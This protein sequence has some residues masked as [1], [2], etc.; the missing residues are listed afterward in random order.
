[1]PRQDDLNAIVVNDLTDIKGRIQ[2]L[3]DVLNV[4]DWAI[5]SAFEQ[6]EE[7]GHLPPEEGLLQEYRRAI[8]ILR[9]RGFTFPKSSGK[10]VACPGCKALL[11]D[12]EGKPG[13]RCGWCGH[14]F[15]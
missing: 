11:R 15:S 5:D 13:E 8:K 12:I 9:H 10:G 14:E 3:T 2:V 1:M 6:F 7:S 4:M